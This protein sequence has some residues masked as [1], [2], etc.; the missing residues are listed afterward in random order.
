ML[1]AAEDFRSK[2]PV[3]FDVVI[4]T[5]LVVKILKIAAAERKS[6]GSKKKPNSAAVP[7]AEV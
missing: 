5:G 6:R 2:K 1:V 7:R 4:E 3:W